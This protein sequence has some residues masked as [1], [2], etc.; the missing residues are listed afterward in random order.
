MENVSCLFASGTHHPHKAIDRLSLHVPTGQFVAIM[1]PTGSGKTTL[2]QMIS[3]LI[4]PSSGELRVG[5]FRMTKKADRRRLW[6]VLGYLFQF[7]EYQVFEDTVFHHVR[8]QLHRGS[9]GNECITKRAKEALE[10]VGLSYERF[11]DLS[12]LQLSGGELKRA[13]LAGILLAEPEILILDEPTAEL[14]GS[15]RSRIL[16]LLKQ[17][18]EKNRMTVLYI[19]H[20]LEEALEYSERILVFNQGQLYADIHPSQIQSRWSELERIGFVRTPLLRYIESLEKH[21]ALRVPEEAYKEEQLI[22]YVVSL[23]WEE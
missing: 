4:P 18:H 15:E 23:K 9:M 5:P 20:R 7:P 12:V 1:G 8:G 13:A 22:S 2:V 6:R 10:A 19:T 11:K 21:L 16:S 14:D 17:I 3:G